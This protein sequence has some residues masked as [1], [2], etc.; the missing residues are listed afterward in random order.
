MADPGTVQILIN[1]EKAGIYDFTEQDK[2]VLRE[3][4]DE[5]NA[6]DE[7]KNK[8]RKVEY[9]SQALDEYPWFCGPVIV[10]YIERF[11]SEMARAYISRFLM[12]PHVNYI[13][14]KD[15]GAYYFKLYTH[16]KEAIEKGTRYS[17]TNLYFIA[18]LYDNLLSKTI[19]KAVALEVVKL[20]DDPVEYY[21]LFYT[22]K[23]IA[24]KWKLPE[25]ERMAYACLTTYP[26]NEETLHINT[27]NRLFLP[28]DMVINSIKGLS[29]RCLSNYPSKKNEEILMKYCTCGEKRK[30]ELA[31]KH[32]ALLRKNAEKKGIEL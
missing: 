10:K 18:N 15:L 5:I 16:F 20:I 4:L 27:L 28:F 32:L 1:N 19:T 17:P 26:L 23:R 9:L 22:T 7:F 25:I 11:D 8:D 13:N 29:I 3:M 21:S 31:T 6:L 24:D 2:I 12:E 14:K 30:E